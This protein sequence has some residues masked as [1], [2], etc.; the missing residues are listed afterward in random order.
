MSINGGR[1]V[2][3]MGWMEKI[4]NKY[5]TYIKTKTKKVI[6]TFYLT[7]NQYNSSIKKIFR[8]Y[9]KVRIVRHKFRIVKKK[10]SFSYLFIFLFCGR[11]KKTI[12]RHKLGIARAKMSEF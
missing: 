6:A 9:E 10:V 2:S 3:T 12:V 1:L 8:N 7:F 11:K 4:I 5:C